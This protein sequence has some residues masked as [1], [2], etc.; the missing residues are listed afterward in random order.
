MSEVEHALC[1]LASSAMLA[2]L[3]G[4]CHGQVQDNYYSFEPGSL[5]GSHDSMKLCL[6]YEGDALRRYRNV[7]THFERD[8]KI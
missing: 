3:D 5:S 8:L 6:Y 2:H 4:N 7:P 1:A